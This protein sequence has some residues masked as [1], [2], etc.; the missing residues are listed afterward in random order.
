MPVLLRDMA[1]DV[2]RLSLAG[3]LLVGREG[4]RVVAGDIPRA[5]LACVEGR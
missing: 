3:P 2:P 5:G 1:G 4:G